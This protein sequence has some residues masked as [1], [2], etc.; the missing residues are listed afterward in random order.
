MR[1][2][3]ELAAVPMAALCLS[4][5]SREAGGLGQA[6]RAGC[7]AAGEEGPRGDLLGP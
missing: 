7:E 3:S 6:L 4:S 1:L 5:C 2:S